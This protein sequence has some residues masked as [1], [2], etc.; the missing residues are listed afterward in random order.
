MEIFWRLG[1]LLESFVGHGYASARWGF[2]A[3]NG[4][5]LTILSQRLQWR[6]GRRRRPHACS[7]AVGNP[8]WPAKAALGGFQVMR[9]SIFYLVWLVLQCC[10]W[11]QSPAVLQ[12]RRNRAMRMLPDGILLLHA[13]NALESETAPYFR[14]QPFFYYFTG[15]DDGASLI[16]AIDAPK[17]ESWLF[18]PDKLSGLLGSLTPAMVASSSE[19]AQKTGV[20]HVALWTELASYLDQRLSA[21]HPPVLYTAEGTGWSAENLPANITQENRP[22]LFWQYAI[23]HRWAKA[24]VSPAEDKLKELLR[25]KEPGEIERL[26]MAGKASASTFL[27]ALR[28]IAVGKSQRQIE[29]QIVLGCFEA[30]ADGPAFWP[31]AMS[32]EN[33][34]FPRPFS[35]LAD[36]HHF[37]KKLEPGELVRLDLGCEVNHYGGDV[38]RTV[39]VSGQFEAGQRETWN[40]LVGAYR[41]GLARVR[42]GA[43]IQDIRR[44][45]TEAI[46]RNQPQLSTSLAQAAARA[47]LAPKGAPFWSIHTV[48]LRVDDVRDSLRTGMVVA[49]EPIVSVQGQG[50][51]LEDMLLITKEGYEVLTP[52]LPYTAEEI[53]QAMNSPAS[54]RH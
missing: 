25:D 44:A 51:Y 48:G 1:V 45:W 14:Q 21:K 9:T 13:T 50:F 3:P 23:A 37:N 10:C 36:Y 11:A 22:D 32:G 33:G 40:M 24:K 16:L 29:G 15:L 27:A 18:V 39:P 28:T 35:A 19:L 49:Y 31:W 5:T 41:A 53:E 54:R 38:G 42:N 26:R 4:N 43:K 20:Q 7:R 34:A 12:A 6:L 30:G 47:I 8:R 17:H 52:G 46:A 2:K